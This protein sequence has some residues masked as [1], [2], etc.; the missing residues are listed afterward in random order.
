MK[1]DW[2]RQRNR[3]AR[4]TPR[5]TP[6][7][8]ADGG[9]EGMR[10][11]DARPAAACA[12]LSSGLAASPSRRG[13]LSGAVSATAAR[14]S[15]ASRLARS[16]SVLTASENRRLAPRMQPKEPDSRPKEPKR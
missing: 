14:T 13:A 8:R 15:S 5:L 6:E 11:S 3:S 16:R 9:I 10:C 4:T 2:S 1:A 7:R 12:A